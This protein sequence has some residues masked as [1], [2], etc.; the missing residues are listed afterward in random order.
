MDMGLKSNQPIPVRSQMI[1]GET[2]GPG[3]SN[4]VANSLAEQYAAGDHHATDGAVGGLPQEQ[5]D[6]GDNAH[7]VDSHGDRVDV[8]ERHV[9]ADVVEQLVVEPASLCVGLFAHWVPVK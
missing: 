5:A 4:G 6:V 7:F 1:T 2:F 9:G 8:D 3:G